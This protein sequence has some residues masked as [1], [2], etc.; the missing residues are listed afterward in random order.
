MSDIALVILFNHN[1]EANIEKLQKIYEPRFSNIFFIMPFYKGD[2]SNVIPVYENS[3]Y[4][5]GYI[6]KTL[7][8]ISNDKYSH[9]MFI[10]DDLILN[11]AINENNYK[12]FF[13]LND[14]SG[15]MPDL[16]LL[17]DTKQTSPDR[18]LAPYWPGVLDAVRFRIKQKG[19]EISKFL[20]A[21][22]VNGLRVI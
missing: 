3:L 12:D 2:K 7:E 20:P 15:F 19:I 1:Y 16:F 21:F 17:T 18:P 11:P 4:F 8:K 9:Y 10:G 6:S 14:R 13:K 22:F 5:Q